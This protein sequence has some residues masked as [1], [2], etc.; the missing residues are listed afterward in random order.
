MTSNSIY[1]DT[2]SLYST[3]LKILKNLPGLNLTI[4]LQMSPGLENFFHELSN[5]KYT[6][7]LR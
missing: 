7:E 5:G 3:D 4:D 6:F 2:I 1:V